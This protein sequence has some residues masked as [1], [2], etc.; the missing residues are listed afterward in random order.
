MVTL[1]VT[2]IA[3]AMLFLHVLPVASAHVL[4]PTTR[5]KPTNLPLVAPS[6][7][8]VL[9]TIA[10]ATPVLL[11]SLVPVLVV[12]GVPT[13]PTVVVSV[14][15]VMVVTVSLVVPVPVMVSAAVTTVHRVAITA[16][17]VSQQGRTVTLFDRVGD[18]APENDRD[19]TFVILLLLLLAEGVNSVLPVNI[20]IAAES[21]HHAIGLGE[22]DFLASLGT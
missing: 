13:A 14:P 15:P 16:R 10:T 7:P 12:V 11:P 19:A 17:V 1:S 5:S 22:V 6:L 9:T 3:T 2:V 18:Q 8:V 20:D 4:V 21:K